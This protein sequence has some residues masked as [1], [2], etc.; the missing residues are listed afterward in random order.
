[1][2]A[3][4]RIETGAGQ[5]QRPAS[6]VSA[7]VGLAGL[8]GLGVWTAV[9]WTYGLQ[10]PL[11]ALSALAACGVPMILWS[12]LVDKVHRNRSTGIDWD[13][14]PRP[15]RDSLDISL[16]KIAGLW[17]IWGAITCMANR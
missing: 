7:G 4:T 16:V 3:E 12:L 10:G 17:A 8:V 5:E 11:G 9:A 15:L 1:M 13:S 14:P 2:N 6:A